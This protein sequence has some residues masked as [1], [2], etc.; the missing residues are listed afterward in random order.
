MFKK[1]NEGKL[2]DRASLRKIITEIKGYKCNVCGLNEWNYKEITLQVNHIDGDCTNNTIEN[3]ELICP[4]CHSQTNTFGG[5]N[6][7]F[8]RKSR[9]LPRHY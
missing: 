1:F 2:S 8:G 5:K 6:K 3:L 7:G 4:N 9:G